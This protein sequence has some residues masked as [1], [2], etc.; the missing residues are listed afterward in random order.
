MKEIIPSQSTLCSNHK[1]T[2]KIYLLKKMLKTKN[3]CGY[4]QAVWQR[5][6][7]LTQCQSI[8]TIESEVRN[9]PSALEPHSMDSLGHQHYTKK[10]SLNIALH[11]KVL[12]E[13]KAT[14]PYY[15]NKRTRNY[16]Q[17]TFFSYF[18]T[19]NLFSKDFSQQQQSSSSISSSC[20][21]VTRCTHVKL[22]TDIHG[23]QGY[24]FVLIFLAVGVIFFWADKT[25]M[26]FRD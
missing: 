11:F 24:F 25:D 20:L 19:F 12:C 26:L 4:I 6:F 8:S 13:S 17:K 10:L 14:L 22:C 9:L 18:L 1:S 15:L 16:F 3:G 2:F 23:I 5:Y 7:T 21:I